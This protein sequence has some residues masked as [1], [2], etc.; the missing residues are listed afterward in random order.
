MR[1]HSKWAKLSAFDSF[2]F[3][4]VS[5]VQILDS[6]PIFFGSPQIDSSVIVGFFS[7]PFA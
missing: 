1:I 5:L 2:S 7:S 4:K 3:A 6:L